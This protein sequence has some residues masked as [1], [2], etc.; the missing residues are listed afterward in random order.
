MNKRL[1][2]MTLVMLLALSLIAIGCPPAAEE[3]VGE[4][5]PWPGYPNPQFVWRVQTLAPAGVAAWYEPF[6]DFTERVREI[7]GGRL[8]IKPFPDGAIVGT[9]KVFDAVV[10]RTFEGFHSWPAYWTGKDPAFASVSGMAMGF[11]E[12]WMM[13]AWFWEWGG[14]DLVRELYAEHDLFFVGPVGYGAEIM[15]F[16]YPVDDLDDFAGLLFRTPA[17]QTAD[18]LTAMGAAVTIL[19]GGE[20]FTALELGVIEGF[21]WC[22]IPINFPMG[23]HKLAP[24]FIHPGF[25]MTAGATEFVVHMDV[26][27]ALPADLQHLVVAAVREWSYRNYQ[28]VRVDEVYYL[29][30]ML[31]DGNVRMD[32]PEEDIETIRRLALDVWERWAGRTP[33]SGA[34]IESKMEFMRAIGILE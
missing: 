19:P 11:P 23:F 14:I 2:S 27:N 8:I 22:P 5:V 24:Y 25:H 20:I 28:R 32:F 9:F 16:T 10:A 18:L 33:M 1:L 6:E 21:E 13:Q 17:G 7:S 30:K 34:I 15:Q 4:I 12:Q 29:D 31:A 3:G 26:W